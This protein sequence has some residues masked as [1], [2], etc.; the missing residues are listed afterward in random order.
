MALRYCWLWQRANIRVFLARCTICM[1]NMQFWKAWR[2][3]RLPIG[4]LFQIVA[5]GIFGSLGPTAK[6]HTHILVLIDHHTRRL[7]L[8]ALPEP[9]AE[10]VAKAI[11]E[12]LISRWGTI[13][14]LLIDSKF[15]VTARLCSSL[16][17]SMGSSPSTV[18]PKTRVAILSWSRI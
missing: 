5:T 4:A 18:R 2:W 9:T 10:L 6:G 11:F 1:A 3:L 14:A 7:E 8:I 15:Q 17:M 16:P 12:Q 13:R